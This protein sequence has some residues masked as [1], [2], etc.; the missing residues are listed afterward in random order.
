MCRHQVGAVSNT[1]V[2]QDEWDAQ[3]IELVARVFDF[4]TRGQRYQ[5][6]HPGFDVPFKFCP[7]CGEAID[8]RSM[9]LLS[10][11]D[12]VEKHTRAQACSGDTRAGSV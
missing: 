3:L 8:H 9:G 4:N 5:V 12:A 11:T 7:A 1:V 6:S 2:Y 10:Y